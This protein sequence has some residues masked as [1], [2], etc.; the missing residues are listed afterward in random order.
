MANYRLTGT[1][2]GTVRAEAWIVDGVIAYRPP[3]G[4]VINI[5]GFIYPGLLDAHTHPGLNRDGNLL[6]HQ[7]V[8]AVRSFA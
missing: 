5:R 3:Q 1:L 8:Q 7:E 2:R 6:P 4:R